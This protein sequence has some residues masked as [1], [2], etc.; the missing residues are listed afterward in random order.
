MENNLRFIPSGKPQHLNAG[1]ENS[2]PISHASTAHSEFAVHDAFRAGV[3]QV[4]HD[5]MPGHSLENH[6]KHVN[7]IIMPMRRIIRRRIRS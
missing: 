2:A 7:L 6:L 3:N 1:N 4:R 5:L